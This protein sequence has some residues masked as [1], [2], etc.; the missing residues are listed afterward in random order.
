MGKL[1]CFPENQNNKILYCYLRNL[2]S[3]VNIMST[4]RTQ[5]ENKQAEKNFIPNYNYGTDIHGLF[6]GERSEKGAEGRRA[7]MKEI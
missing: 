2:S 6:V 1:E 5:L 3:G 4:L 7:A